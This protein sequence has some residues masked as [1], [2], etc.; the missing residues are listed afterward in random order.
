MEEIDVD[1]IQQ[2]IIERILIEFRFK[3]NILLAT[4]KVFVYD[5]DEKVYDGNLLSL[6]ENSKIVN[7][8]KLDNKLLSMFFNS[9][10]NKEVDKEVKSL[11]S[12]FKIDAIIWKKWDDVWYV[13]D[14]NY[15]TRV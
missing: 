9:A 7:A 2:F 11:V 13:H 15:Q 1:K 10:I 12:V 3:D 14:V 4:N 6:C 5:I 8:H